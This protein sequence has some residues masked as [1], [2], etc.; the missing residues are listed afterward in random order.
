LADLERNWVL[1]R[2][3]G[4]GVDTFLKYAA[5]ASHWGE[6]T[7]RYQ[8]LPHPLPGRKMPKA[9][10]R[11]LR[12]LERE[13][14]AMPCVQEWLAQEHV[15]GVIDVPELKL[16]VALFRAGAPRPW[17]LARELGAHS[18]YLSMGNGNMEWMDLIVNNS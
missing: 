17:R 16:R 14:A 13:L 5:V 3:K 15:L 2:L 10:G 11:Q 18:A 8:C 6:W 1:P 7:L 12:R 9:R 4:A